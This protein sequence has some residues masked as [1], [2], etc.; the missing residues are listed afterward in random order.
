MR[1]L[2]APGLIYPANLAAQANHIGANINVNNN[3]WTV[4]PIVN[5]HNMQ[6]YDDP[7]PE[8]GIPHPP[9]TNMRFKRADY[10]PVKPTLINI[11]YTRYGALLVDCNNSQLHDLWRQLQL[12]LSS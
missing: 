10:S 4:L 3:T 2:N 7:Y 6:P 9:A 1:K 11:N 8:Q 5:H 12:P